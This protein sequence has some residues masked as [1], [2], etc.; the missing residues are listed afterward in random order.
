ME[1]ISIV[2]KNGKCY[3]SGHPGRA[4][5]RTVEDA[6]GV[7][8]FC[9]ENRLDR[10]VLYADNFPK[11]FFDL[12]SQTAGLLLQKFSTYRIR[13]AAVVDLDKKAHSSHFPEMVA[14]ENRRGMFHLCS[15]LE[16]AE[17]WVLR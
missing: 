17:A 4:L 5:I 14:E 6:V 16:E 2:E 12:S 3:A 8:G 7:I 15:S 10:V 9:F 11:N 1:P 13:M